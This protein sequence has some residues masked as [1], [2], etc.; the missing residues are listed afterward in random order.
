MPGAWANLGLHVSLLSPPGLGLPLKRVFWKDPQSAAWDH[1]HRPIFNEGGALAPGQ[2]VSF[3]SPSILKRNLCP[4]YLTSS[5]VAV[6]Y[7]KAHF[8]K[9][10]NFRIYF[11]ACCYGESLLGIRAPA[12]R[13]RQAGQIPAVSVT[14]RCHRSC[15][16]E[17]PPPTEVAPVPEHLPGERAGLPPAAQD[18]G[19]P[20]APP[21]RRGGMRPAPPG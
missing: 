9:L 16:T 15:E 1:E 4:Y 10:R 18:A 11:V 17:T 20:T 14:P 6:N 12:C 13:G 21:E 8:P 19:S 3:T 5:S 7:I 2:L